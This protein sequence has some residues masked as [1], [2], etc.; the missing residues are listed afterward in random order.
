M[1]P[2][3]TFPSRHKAEHGVKKNENTYIYILKRKENK[4]K[5]FSK[6]IVNVLALISKFEVSLMHSAYCLSRRSIPDAPQRGDQ[7][8]TLRS[9]IPRGTL[10]GEASL[11]IE[12]IS[13]NGGHYTYHKGKYGT[14]RAQKQPSLIS[15]RNQVLQAPTIL[16][17]LQD[18]DQTTNANQNA[19]IKF[20]SSSNGIAQN[21]KQHRRLHEPQSTNRITSTNTR[22]QNYHQWPE[23]QKHVPL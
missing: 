18:T 20:Q 16:A 13:A 22:Q 8:V 19:L 12:V 3:V 17:E 5:I 23:T 6:I 1:G 10:P 2:A 11:I 21:R 15:I 7:L 14:V 9:L 4:G